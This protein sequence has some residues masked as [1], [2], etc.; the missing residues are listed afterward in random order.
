LIKK[1]SLSDGVMVTDSRFL[2]TTS[3]AFDWDKLLGRL[4]PIVDQR[5]G[6]SVTTV[7]QPA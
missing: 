4:T 6:R 3:T 7:P 2:R 5:E 1:A